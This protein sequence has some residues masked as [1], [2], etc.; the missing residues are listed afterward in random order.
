MSES[1]RELI[2]S[3]GPHT[4]ESLAE[5][6]PAFP[7]EA[8]REALDAL[9]AQGVLERSE[10]PDGTREYRYVAPEL[11]A[12]ANMD[13]IKDPSARFNRRRR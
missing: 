4:A 6:L 12:Q 10:R 9:A 3:P 7:V 8:I 11:Y 5:R 13:V 2:Q 1:L